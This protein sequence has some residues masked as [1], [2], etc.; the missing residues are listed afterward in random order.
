MKPA[1]DPKTGRSQMNKTGLA[2]KWKAFLFTVMCIK[3][4]FK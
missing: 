4:L 3:L 2:C 1:D